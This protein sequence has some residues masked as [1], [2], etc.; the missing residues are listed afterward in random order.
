MNLLETYHHTGCSSD[1]ETY[2]HYI[3]KFYNNLLTPYKNMK[4]NL[5]EIGVQYGHSLK[6]WDDFFDKA[7]IYGLDTINLLQHKFSH[8]V[9]TMGGN[10]YSKESIYYFKSKNITFDII[11]DDGPHTLES[12]IFFIN[13]YID[14]LNP[15]GYLIIEDVYSN[16]ILTLQ[17][18]YTNFKTID[19]IDL[20]P[21]FPKK[22]NNSIIFY[23]QKLQ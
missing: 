23:Y 14:L 20:E 15:N 22:E 8:K 19:L 3:S 18:K 21:S 10:A 16:N 5:L 1:K 9:I 12:Q 11:I 2:H 13:N 4:F 6:L 17:H 7:I